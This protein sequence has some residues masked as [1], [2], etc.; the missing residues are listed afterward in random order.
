[1][2]VSKKGDCYLKR[3]N[4][5]R[6]IHKPVKSSN[7]AHIHFFIIYRESDEVTLTKS[8]IYTNRY[9]YSSMHSKIGQDIVTSFIQHTVQYGT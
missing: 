9:V 4:Q 3:R 2:E 8:Q 1:M 7:V 5:G 6:Q